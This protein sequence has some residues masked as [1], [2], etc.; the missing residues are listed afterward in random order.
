[1]FSRGKFYGEKMIRYTKDSKTG[2][3]ILEWEEM[4]RGN[5]SAPT[6]S[7]YAKSMISVINEDLQAIQEIRHEG[8]EKSEEKICRCDIGSVIMNPCRDHI[9]ISYSILLNRVSAKDSDAL[10]KMGF[11]PIACKD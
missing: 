6:V 5:V 2:G 4:I 3:K 7:G 11:I 8:F 1:M 10:I 9:S